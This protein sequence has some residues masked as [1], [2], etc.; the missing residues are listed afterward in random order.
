MSLRNRGFSSKSVV[1]GGSLKGARSSVRYDGRASRS[2][3]GVL[4]TGAPPPEI[5][6][7]VQDVRSQEKDQ[8]RGLN[9]RF[10]NFI[11]KV[12]SLEQQ[13]SV[14]DAQWKVLQAKGED[15]SNLEDIYQEYIRGLRRQ[16][17][18]LQENK[19]H[20]QSDVGHMQGVVEEFK[21]KYETELNNRNHAEN[22]FV[23]IKKDFDDAH[24]NK[25]ELEARLEGLTD[26]IDFLRRIYEEELRELHAQMNNISLTVEVDTNRH[27]NMDDIV[28]SVRSQYE[29]LAQQS[30]QEAE[31]FYRVKFEDINASADKSNE[32]IRNSKQEL[33]DLLRTIK[34]LT[35]EVQRLKQQR[36]Q[37]ERA[38]AEAEDLGEQALKDAK[39]R[40][41]DL[42][43]ELAD[44]RRQMAQ[45]VRDYQELM[46]VKLALDIEIATYGKLLEGEEDRLSSLAGARGRNPRNYSYNFGDDDL[47]CHY[48]SAVPRSSKTVIIKSIE[49]QDGSVVS[50]T[51]EV[52]N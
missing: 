23:L 5:D 28:A 30:R 7:S 27:F 37:A 19:E 2:S 22:E 12:R 31:D 6:R 47:T 21:N 26:E 10:A 49:T 1:T 50:E 16:L 9:D 15:K 25:V 11:D 32:D 52:R 29:A 42:E 48:E 36:G 3:A 51:T 13:R 18:M 14:L 41:A 20:L 33:N 17:E 35:S 38:V 46:N 34:N 24:L 44:S 40:I 8:I 39:K 4:F 45:H 43:Q